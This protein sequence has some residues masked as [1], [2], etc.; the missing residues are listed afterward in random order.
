MIRRIPILF[1]VCISLSIAQLKTVSI[2]EVIV[3]ATEAWNNPVFSPDGKSIFLTNSSYDG[4]WHFALESKVL[5]EI[6]REQ[7]SGFAFDISKDGKNIAYRRTIRTGDHI[8]RIQES[9]SKNI[10]TGSTSVIE[11]GNSV[12]TP[13]FVGTTAVSQKSHLQKISH[14]VV[15]VV[16]GIADAKISML[17]NGQQVMFDPL[18]GQYIWPRLSPDA[19]RLVAV[20]MDRG[21]FVYSFA[22]ANTQL[23]GK[24]N[25][26]TWSSDGKWVIGMDDRDDGHTIYASDIIA[27]TPDGKTKVTLTDTFDGIALYPS[28]S[29][30]ENK[31]LF[32]TADGKIFILSFKEVK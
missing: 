27:V 26:P 23:I 9:V 20:E 21:A 31:V 28:A 3:P 11:R 5:K 7:H 12:H 25:S 17:I 16:L 8:T 30:V 13:V 24:C 14:S 29:P 2:E 22:N 4:I 10:L 6:T 1:I 15:P 18:N 32:N 19:R